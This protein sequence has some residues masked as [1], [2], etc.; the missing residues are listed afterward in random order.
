MNASKGLIEAKLTLFFNFFAT[1]FRYKE[2]HSMILCVIIVSLIQ[3]SHYE[4]RIFVVCS[5]QFCKCTYNLMY[6]ILFLSYHHRTIFVKCSRLSSQSSVRLYQIIWEVFHCEE[7]MRKKLSGK[8]IYDIVLTR[9]V[10]WSKINVNSCALLRE[11]NYFLSFSK[12][13]MVCWLSCFLVF[14]DGEIFYWWKVMQIR[15]NF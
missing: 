5:F 3:F 9:V 1:S 13:G 4:F 15:V 6:R 14:V 12:T 8:T 7:F 11:E 2:N 10:E